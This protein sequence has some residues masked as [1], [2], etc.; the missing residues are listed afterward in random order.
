MVKGLI[1]SRSDRRISITEHTLWRKTEIAIFVY[2]SKH[3]NK[4]ATYRDITR[5]YVK[6]NYSNFQK[7]CEELVQRGYLIKLEDG[8]FKVRETEWEMVRTGKEKILRRLPCF[9]NYLKKLKH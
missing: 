3:K 6:S 4:P 1:G 2:F 5:A 8:K 7:A 9:D